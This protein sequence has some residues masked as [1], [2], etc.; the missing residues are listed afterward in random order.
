MKYN[1]LTQEIVANALN[2]V[3]KY[4]EI[5]DQVGREILE[6]RLDPGAWAAA[7]AASEGNR[8][9]ALSRYARIRME[10]LEKHHRA[11]I[12]KIESFE[13][14][15]VSQCLGPKKQ[16]NLVR[17][18]RE[19]L[20]SPR[21]GKALNF[22]KPSLSP[23]WL[24]ILWVG[25]AGTL[26]TLGHLSSTRLSEGITTHLTSISACCGLIV[27]GGALLLRQTL[28]KPWI[29]QC[30]NSGL[31]ATCNLVCLSSL[32]LGTKVI[33]RSMAMEVALVPNQQS[34]IA[35]SARFA[36]PDLGPPGGQCLVS[37]EI[38]DVAGAME[39]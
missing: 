39:D 7:L 30:W 4:P 12:A 36:K 31:V 16:A 9:K 24:M 38:V 5:A 26:A 10:S 27:V 15:R 8:Q 13:C 14:R 17:S 35:N 37:S 29:L 11:R 22:M 1:P 33:K 25:S 19:L 21:P 23:L 20:D 18:V 28:P 32:F 34:V 6:S 2:S 3:T